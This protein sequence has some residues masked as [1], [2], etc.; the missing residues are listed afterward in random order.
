MLYGACRPFYDCKG[1]RRGRIFGTLRPGFLITE[2][3]PH[4]PKL[5]SQVIKATEEGG[6]LVRTP[7]E[8]VEHA[9]LPLGNPHTNLLTSKRR[10]VGSRKATGT[11]NTTTPIISL[12]V[13]RYRERGNKSRVLQVF[14]RQTSIQKRT[15]MSAWC[16]SVEV[17]GTTNGIH[18]L[19]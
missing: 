16:G 15:K 9:L 5:N 7:G 4:I 14:R 12:C 10:S 19:A 2:V 11:T 13:S 17:F 8:M 18:F 3:T 1:S 6:I